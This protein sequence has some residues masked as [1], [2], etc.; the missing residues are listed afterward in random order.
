[1]PEDNPY[2]AWSNAI[3]DG[4]IER[5][6]EGDPSPVGGILPG[7]ERLFGWLPV[8]CLFAPYPEGDLWWVVPRANPYGKPYLARVY[9]L[10]ELPD[11]G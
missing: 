11:D 9:E 5:L 3:W 2:E 1:M 7:D 6:A 8:V 10:K 4:L